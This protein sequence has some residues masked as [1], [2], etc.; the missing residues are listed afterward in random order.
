MRKNLTRVLLLSLLLAV[1]FHFEARPA[2]A[3]SFQ[4][5][6][7]LDK[8]PAFDT[9]PTALQASDGTL[10]VAWDTEFY[11]QNQIGAMTYSNGV[12]SAQHNITWGPPSQANTAPAL[13]QLVNGSIILVWSSN[14]TGF[15]NL[16][17]KFFNSGVWSKTIYQLTASCAP[18]CTLGD[19]DFSPK[20]LVGLDST[21]WVVWE[22]DVTVPAATCASGFTI[23]CRQLF[24][25]T[26]R[27]S[28]WSSEA[29][30]TSD[31]TWNR[32]PGATIT[33]DG[34]VWV[35]Y[36]KWI[37]KGS[38]YNL[39]SRTFNGTVWSAEV[40]R[41]NINALDFTPDIVQDRNGTM[42]LLW[43]RDISVG[44]GFFNDKVFYE[45]SPDGGTTWSSATQ[46]T[47]G[48]T[49]VQPIDDREPIPVQGNTRNL[50]GT[51]DHSL[52][53]FYDSDAFL[54]GT[55][56]AIYYI[57]TN[58]I[59][60]VHDVAVTGIGASPSK[61]F[62][63]GIRKLNIT[64]ATVTVQISNLGDFPENISYSVQAV[65]TTTFNIASSWALF[66]SGLSKTYTFSWNATLATPGLYTIVASLAPIAGETIGARMDDT[67]RFKSLGIVYPGDLDLSGH[68]NI[69]DASIFGV[70]WQ[71]RP[72][73]PNWNPD[74]DIVYNGMVDI[75]DAS[76]FGANWQKSI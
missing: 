60:P 29:Q 58:N 71:S 26:L 45:I 55:D 46:L 11:G 50:D 70:A 53:I 35:V 27:G 19:G 44:G 18:G 28:V 22:R 67:L 1:F 62:P 33:K 32:W 8:A 41:T 13:A 37:S 64:S 63:W 25:K 66:S 31:V 7:L 34:S 14:Q 42:W 57:K 17:Y 20:V 68:V 65:N 23:V 6:Q 69:L 61:M 54:N 43:D 51:I 76:V 75:L 73:M 72:G 56:F 38:N 4:S 52:W 21:V 24:Y 74:A 2:S 49:S 5:P 3:Y 9:Q 47:F 15:Y 40:Q 48:G 39:F 10:W 12:W 36:S 59:F 16:Y 30:L